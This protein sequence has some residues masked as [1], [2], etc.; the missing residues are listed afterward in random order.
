MLATIAPEPRCDGP[1]VLRRRTAVRHLMSWTM[2]ASGGHWSIL[3][4][5][6]PRLAGRR[7][8][9]GCCAGS[10]IVGGSGECRSHLMPTGRLGGECGCPCGRRDDPRR[11]RD[12]AARGAP[13]VMN[14]QGGT[15]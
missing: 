14:L 11:H 4:Q 9:T 8:R 3:D 7:A 15:A 2:H 6:Q 13:A 5:R 1:S 10:D 12:L